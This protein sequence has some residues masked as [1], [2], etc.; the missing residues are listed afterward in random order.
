M[1]SNL[2]VAEALNP[3]VKAG[4]RDAELLCGQEPVT[5]AENQG[6]LDLLALHHLH[7]PDQVGACDYRVGYDV[8]EI[9]IVEQWAHA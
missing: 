1:G 6:S 4:F 3:A 5:F 9:R 2:F 8:E 7:R